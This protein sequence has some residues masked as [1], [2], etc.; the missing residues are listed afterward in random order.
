M[1]K[2]TSLNNTKQ[3]AEQSSSVGANKRVGKR[4]MALT[5]G[6]T[7]NKKLFEV[8]THRNSLSK[9][10]FNK[11]GKGAIS[12]ISLFDGYS[13]KK[14]AT[15]NASSASSIVFTSCNLFN[16][17][18]TSQRVIKDTINLPGVKRDGAGKGRH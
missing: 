1:T 8:A 13:D 12:T 2:A 6:D 10:R 9:Q 16:Q 4:V 18:N 5:L 17:N 14:S 15:V 3:D 11:A 7:E